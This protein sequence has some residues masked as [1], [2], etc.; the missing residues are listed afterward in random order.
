MSILSVIMITSFATPSYSE[1]MSPTKQLDSGMLPEDIQ[2]R[3]DRVLV[4]RTNGNVA[5]VTEKSAERMGWELIQNSISLIEYEFPLSAKVNENGSGEAKPYFGDIDFTISNLPKIGETAEITLTFT[6]KMDYDIPRTDYTSTPLEEIHSRYLSNIVITDNFE[7]VGESDVKT[8]TNT[9]KHSVKELMDTISPNQS[10]IKTVT[11]KA[12]SEGFGYVEAHL[13]YDGARFNVYVGDNET[14]LKDD[15]MIK[16]PQIEQASESSSKECPTNEPCPEPEPELPTENDEIK[17]KSTIKASTEEDIRTFLKETMKMSDEEIEEYI[18]ENW[19]DP[20]ASTQSF[21]LTPAYASSHNTGDYQIYGIITTS[22]TPFSP[23]VATTVH[24]TNVCAWEWDYTNQ[25]YAD[26]I[27]ALTNSDGGYIINGIS[28]PDS[29]TD[30]T[31][32]IVMTYSTNGAYSFVA[33]YSGNVDEILDDAY[34]IEEPAVNDISASHQ[35]DFEIETDIA[36][37]NSNNAFWILDAIADAR[38]FI[39]DE[40]AHGSDKVHVAWQFNEHTGVFDGGAGGAYYC[41]SDESPWFCER[42][43]T[44]FLDGLDSDRPDD[45]NQRYTIMHEYGHF[46]MND[47][48]GLADLPIPDCSSHWFSTTSTETCGWIEGWA[49]ILPPLVDVSATYQIDPDYSIDFENDIV[50]DN[51]TDPPTDDTFYEGLGERVEGHVASAIWDLYDPIDLGDSANGGFDDI[52]EG[53]DKIGWTFL[54]KPVNFEEFYNAW[55]DNPA[56]PDSTNVMQLHYME[57]LPTTPGNTAPVANDDSVELLQDED[58]DITL[59]ATDDDGDTLT[60]TIVTYP[61]EGTLT[62]GL[63]EQYQTYTPDLGFYGTDSFTFKVNDGT[64]DSNTAT[65]SITVTESGSIIVAIIGAT[66]DYESDEIQIQFDTQ[67]ATDFLPSDFDV[68]V[69]LDDSTTQDLTVT[70]VTNYDVASAYR[71]LEFSA[72]PSNTVH[73]Y[74]DVTNSDLGGDDIAT[75]DGDVDSEEEEEIE[76]E[77][78]KP[79]ADAGSNQ[80]VFVGDTVTLDGTASYDDNGDALTYYWEQIDSSGYD[81]G[82]TGSTLSIVTFTAP[83]VPTYTELKFELTVTEQTDEALDHDDSL[84]VFVSPISNSRDADFD[85]VNPDPHGSYDKFGEFMDTNG[86]SVLAGMD[87]NWIRDVTASLSESS[88]SKPEVVELTFENNTVEFPDG[89]VYEI[90]DTIYGT[91]YDG[92]INSE[93]HETVNSDKLVLLVDNENNIVS[94]I[95]SETSEIFAYHVYGTAYFFEYDDLSNYASLQGETGHY[96]DGVEFGE[97]LTLLDSVTVALGDEDYSYYDNDGERTHFQSG[98]V[99]VYDNILIPSVNEK[100]SFLIENPELMV[101]YRDNFGRIITNVGTDKIA[102]SGGALSNIYLYQDYSTLIQSYPSPL[103]GDFAAD[104]MES[105]DYDRFVVADNNLVYVFN[106]IDTIPET[107]ITVSETIKAISTN[108][109]KDW[110]LVG[111]SSNVYLYDGTGILLQDISIPYSASDVTFAKNKIVVGMGTADINGISNAG[112]VY[113]YSPI[114]GSLL[115]SIENDVVDEDLGTQVG[116][117]ESGNLIVVSVPGF[118]DFTESEFDEIGKINFYYNNVNNIPIANAD[119]DLTRAESGDIVT[120]NATD[121]FDLDA[122][123]LTFSWSQTDTTS[124]ITTLSDNT[125]ST[126]TF[127]APNVSEETVLTFE[128][129]VSDGVANNTDSVSVTILPDTTLPEI[130]L[131]DSTITIEVDSIFTDPGYSASD[132]VDGD[133]TSSVLVTGSLDTSTVGIYYLYYDV[134]DSSGNAAIQIT[135]TVNVVDILID[136]DIIGDQYV[137]LGQLLTVTN[138]VTVTGNMTSDGGIIIIEDGSTIDGDV[139]TENGGSLTINNSSVTGYIQSEN[140]DS[141]TITD[142]SILF[143]DVRIDGVPIVDISNS[144]VTGNIQVKISAD[145]TLVNNIVGG[146]LRSIDNLSNIVTGNTVTGNIE[147]ENSDSVDMTGNT[148]EQNL[149]VIN[150]T[151]VTIN[152]NQISQNLRVIENDGVSVNYNHANVNIMFIN[153]LNLTYSNNTADG[154]IKINDQ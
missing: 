30:G 8:N 135:R 83:D 27:C 120:L 98:I 9:S 78:V 64:E 140:T 82:V 10:Y 128:V 55:N 130:I 153:N 144:T 61:S 7:F 22:G 12:V 137:G 25:I 143:G 42:T 86:K 16:Y 48:Y 49:D 110:I 134:S 116:Y 32:D 148:T 103:G 65:V 66:I 111:T 6:N 71:T 108:I 126:P 102:I 45:S 79:R 60:F 99:H 133:I 50:T 51:Q 127:T 139:K 73:L 146:N 87:P 121:S 107:T 104:Y 36:V 38:T 96:S 90:I 13:L 19:T 28:L 3:D 29:S 77:N 100:A 74:I 47:V 94:L 40:F 4:L 23:T 75:F 93:L 53:F 132:K 88:S 35:I 89:K 1:Y 63:T 2:C 101:N 80:S 115:E 152:D 124:Y 113:I 67:I 138:G 62:I 97:S 5:C 56:Y 24:D 70:S 105:F 31:I 41:P 122:D 59:A 119:S 20:D 69:T 43:E 11:I 15:Y 154:Q 106:S 21:F 147:S 54:E 44:I 81:L 117:L 85:F 37:E 72:I 145:V 136:S 114:D 58:L 68:T 39:S 26:P 46:V 151:N 129:T 95:D 33:G 149:R 84:Y 109:D 131:T 125:S 76:E 18:K 142:N 17:G 118:E 14:L 112:G 52:S 92:T 141:V 57:F 91:V 34:R 123:D 150:S